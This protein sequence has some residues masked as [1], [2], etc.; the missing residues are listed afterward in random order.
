MYQ[1]H[2]DSGKESVVI[3]EFPIAG[4]RHWQLSLGKI[5]YLLGKEYKEM[6]LKTGAVKLLYTFS[7]RAPLHCH[8]A[9]RDDFFACDQV[10][11]STS[12]IWQLQL[13][14]S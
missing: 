14:K 6:D 3:E 4:W 12:N 5:Y 9:Y 8:M 1:I 10:E 13:S 11:V 7:G 2:L